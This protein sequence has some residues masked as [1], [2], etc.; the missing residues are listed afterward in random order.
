MRI[1]LAV[2]GGVDSMYLA[3]RR[4]E[5]FPDAL[6]AIAHCNFGLRGED[7]DADE[8]FVREWCT[9]EGLTLHTVRFDTRSHAAGNGISI[10]MAARQLR[11]TWFGKLC[12]EYGYDAIAVAHNANDNAETLILNLLRGT[13]SRGVCGM[14]ERSWS[15]E[16]GTTILRPLLTTQRRDIEEWMRAHGMAWREDRSNSSSDY[17]RN[18]I[19][20]E[21]FPQFALINPSF[22][23]TLSRDMQHLRDT[24]AI[25]EDY[26][27]AV[28][29]QVSKTAEDGSPVIDLRQLMAL[30]HWR[31][32]L[33][34]L[35][36]PYRLSEETFDKLTALLSSGRTI[37]GK[38]FESPTH[39]V[40][41]RLKTMT[42]AP[43][44]KQ[45]KG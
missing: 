31:Y 5:L 6:F 1:L 29:G 13:G 23:R 35:L 16:A 32:V 28:R 26:L 21:I 44:Q 3:N 34:R 9:R 10:E 25:A 43:R 2:S 11:Y 14:G 27:A 38:S 18:R 24:D 42:V 12:S 37:S 33:W 30:R 20:N 19:R 41:I 4:Q 17:K 7:S 36:E 22:V 39:I 45:T 8:Q 15:Q 40:S